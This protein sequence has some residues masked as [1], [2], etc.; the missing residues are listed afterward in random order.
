M[1]NI[2]KDVHDKLK[3]YENFLKEEMRNNVKKFLVHFSSQFDVEG[4]N[5]GSNITA[6]VDRYLHTLEEKRE[7]F[8]LQTNGDINEKTIYAAI[9]NQKYYMRHTSVLENLE[10]RKYY[11]FFVTKNLVLE[12]ASF[13]LMRYL[14]IT[15]FAGT[16]ELSTMYING[17][18]CRNIYECIGPKPGE[19]NGKKID[20]C[21]IY[22]YVIE[23]C[24]IEHNSVTVLTTYGRIITQEWEGCNYILNMNPLQYV[25]EEEPPSYDRLV[26]SKIWMDD[27]QLMSKYLD[28]KTTAE[29]E[30]KTY[31]A[32]HPEIKELIADF[33][34][35][36]LLLKPEN[37]L[38][39]TKDYFQNLYPCQTPR[40][41]YCENDRG[42]SNEDVEY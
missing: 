9:Q 35:N 26:M 4:C 24:G 42:K 38:L 10:I 3:E 5:A 8:L 25:G 14:A 31:M 11:P 29:R 22:R 16:I 2:E 32:D 37:I 7:E 33:V 34:Q 12:G 15:Q 23:E 19:V 20:V 36:V 30:M 13:I 27:M 41:P 17:E 40:I 18:M 39:F 28:C 21:K 6:W 1:S